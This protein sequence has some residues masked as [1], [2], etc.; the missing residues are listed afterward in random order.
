MTNQIDWGYLKRTEP[1]T[2]GIEPGTGA[3]F[4]HAHEPRRHQST[5]TVEHGDKIITVTHDNKGR[6]TRPHF[7]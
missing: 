1:G 7:N 2:E 3:Y 4:Y 6:W 5:I